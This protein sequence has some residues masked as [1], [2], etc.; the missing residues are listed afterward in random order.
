M[1]SDKLLIKNSILRMH[2]EGEIIVDQINHPI[3]MLTDHEY[4]SIGH[5]LAFIRTVLPS[6]PKK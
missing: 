3:D 4:D 5:N 6:I 1:T 2:N